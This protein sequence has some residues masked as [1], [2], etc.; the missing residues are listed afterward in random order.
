[1][2]LEEGKTNAI[3]LGEENCVEY[4]WWTWQNSR[5]G[6]GGFSAAF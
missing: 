2:V 6:G 3:L 1:M 4:K 5:L